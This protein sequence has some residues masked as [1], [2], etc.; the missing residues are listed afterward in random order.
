MLIAEGT[1]EPLI[2][3]GNVRLDAALWPLLS[4]RLSAKQVMFKDTVIQLAPQTEAVCGK[5]APVAPEDN[6]LSDLAEDRG[7]PLDIT[8]LRITDSVLVLQHKDDEQVT[9]RGIRLEIEQGNQHRDTLD[10][11][12]CMNRDQR[13]PV[14]SFN[15]TVGVSDHPHNLSAS[16]EQL[17]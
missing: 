8:C 4:H 16:I 7:W 5:D 13:N 3:A 14:L 1:N 17:S 6:M 9:I 2:R 11:S 10:F 12:G 15:D